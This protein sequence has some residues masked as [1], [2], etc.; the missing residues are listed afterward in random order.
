MKVAVMP[1]RTCI[2]DV[3]ALLQDEEADVF[4]FIEVA[5]D[6]VD[7]WL[8][9]SGLSLRILTRIESFLACHFYLLSNPEVVREEYDRARYQ[10]VQPKVEEGFRAT[11]WGQ[12]A[13]ALD[14]T[15]TMDGYN[16]IPVALYVF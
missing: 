9:G 6:I 15:G 4:T 5:N 16:K 8:M 10:Y 13:L 3:R 11:K 14:T 12:M 2:E 7:T 1:L